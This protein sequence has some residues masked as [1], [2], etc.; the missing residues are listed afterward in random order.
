MSVAVGS[1]VDFKLLPPYL[2]PFGYVAGALGL[3]WSIDLAMCARHRYHDA[4]RALRADLGR[5]HVDLAGHP[6]P[7]ASRLWSRHVGRMVARTALV[8]GIVGVA[9][10]A[11]VLAVM[12]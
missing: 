7:D 8:T 5:E 9:A 1:L 4:D 3:L 6:G 10:L 2:G 11:S 12:G